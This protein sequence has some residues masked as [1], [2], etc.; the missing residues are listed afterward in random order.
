[1]LSEMLKYQ[2]QV[3]EMLDS[4]LPK[5]NWKEEFTFFKLQLANLQHERLI[6]LLVTLT[7][8]LGTLMS[9]FTLSIKY[10]LPTL[11]IS[12]ILLPLFMAY[13]FHYFRLENTTQHWYLILERLRKKAGM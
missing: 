11:L 12:I 2:K 8:G 7:V 10:F 3:E 13:I 1:M 4:D 6:H 9:A 5:T